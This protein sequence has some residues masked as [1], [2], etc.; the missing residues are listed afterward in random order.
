MT[1]PI[2]KR[3]LAAAPG[4]GVSLL[5][6]LICPLCWPAYASLLSSLGL[7]FLISTAYLMPLTVAL[8]ALA[9]SSLAFGASRRRG[10]PPFR[11]GLVGALAVITGKF[12]SDSLL[13]AYAGVGGLVISSIWNA[14]PRRDSVAICSACMNMDDG[15]PEIIH[16]DRGER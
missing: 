4:I 14:W 3:T 5:P 16:N 15:S 13:L 9:T 7:G 12:Y 1:W 11:L 10:L 6:K 8:L 2:W